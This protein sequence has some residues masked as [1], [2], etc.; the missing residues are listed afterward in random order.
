MFYSVRLAVD[1]VLNGTQRLTGFY[2]YMTIILS[3]SRNQ[4]Q[5]HAAPSCQS[6]TNLS[7]TPKRPQEKKEKRQRQKKRDSLALRPV[8]LHPVAPSLRQGYLLQPHPVSPAPSAWG[9]A[10]EVSGGAG[11]D[12]PSLWGRGGGGGLHPLAACLCSFLCGV[13]ARLR[14]LWA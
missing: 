10:G 12:A 13:Q 2:I 9:A 1:G 6:R 4:P 14:C 3:P 5:N 7:H 8:L 11:V